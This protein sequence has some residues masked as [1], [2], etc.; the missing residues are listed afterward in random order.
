MHTTPLT[1]ELEDA[2]ADFLADFARAGEARIPAFFGQPEWS[3]AETVRR[4]EAWSR[5]EELAPGAVPNTT[6]FLVDHGRILGVSS[7][8][9]RLNERLERHGGHVGYSVRPS[10]R[11]RGHATEL[12]ARAKEL[13][14]GIGLERLLLTCEP[15]NLG[16]ARTIERNGGRFEREAWCEPEG[17]R[18]RYYWIEL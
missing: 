12:L 11:R 4:F 8:R 7:L 1:L 18:I 9:H 15:H 10:D 3:H 17:H 2:L 13:A 5:G 6:T 14:R 16:S